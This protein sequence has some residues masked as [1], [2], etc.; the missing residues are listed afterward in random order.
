VT[1][2]Y[3]WIQR[4]VPFKDASSIELTKINPSEYSGLGLRYSIRGGEAFSNRFG[5]AVR[6][7]RKKEEQVMFTSENPRRTLGI[8]NEF[9]NKSTKI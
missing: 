2:S 8:M 5:D 9:K 3:W 6:L 1:L 4:V 7:N